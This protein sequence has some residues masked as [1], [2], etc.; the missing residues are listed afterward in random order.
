MPDRKST[1]GTR[2]GRKLSGSQPNLAMLAKPAGTLPSLR[3]SESR[4]DDS[5][6]S[7]TRIAGER[8]Q[9]TV[10]F[11]DIVSSTALIRDL[12]I[13]DSVDL[14]DPLVSSMAAAI[15]AEAG[16]VLRFQGDGLKAVFG[17]PLAQEDHA[18]R[19]CSAA[20][21]IQQSAR[22]Q[23]VAVRIGLNSGEVVVRS[24]IMGGGTFY[25]AGG[26]PVHL[27]ARIEQLARRGSIRVSSSTAHL[28]SRRFVVRSTGPRPIKGFKE[29]VEIFALLGRRAIP[30][31]PRRRAAGRVGKMIGR[32]D[33][34]HRLANILRETESGHGAAVAVTGEPG[35]GKSRLLSELLK[36]RFIRGWTVVV[37]NA[38][39]TDVRSGLRPFANMLRQW[40]AV[41]DRTCPTRIWKALLDHTDA[42]KGFDERDVRALAALLD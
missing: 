9:V 8:K 19:A 22:E 40:L 1:S 23:G 32:A 13:E 34:L 11:V 28:V 42:L 38:Q 2:R 7:A 25:D 33:E 31:G 18:E 39:P 24:F 30:A 35:I 4:P 6:V 16:T 36:S 37:A 29:P 41:G 17:A 5:D 20:L 10:L 15:Q 27:A 12:D 14:L 21:R 26:M 3:N